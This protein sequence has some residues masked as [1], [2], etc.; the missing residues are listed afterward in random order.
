MLLGARFAKIGPRHWRSLPTLGLPTAEGEAAETKWVFPETFFQQLPQVMKDA[1]PLPGEEAK[2]AQIRT[3]LA[4]AERDATIMAAMVDEARKAEVELVD[5]LLQFRNWGV[6][7]DSHWS[8]TN[9]NA[10]FGADYFTRTAVAYTS[11]STNATSPRLIPTRN[12]M[13]SGSGTSALRAA[14]VF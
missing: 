2:C 5:P 3:V 12:T 4:A 8:T 9:N 14:T 13:R 6:Q 1:T 10:A 11:P 7:L